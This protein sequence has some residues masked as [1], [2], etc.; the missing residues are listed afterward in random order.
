MYWF[1]SDNY[2]KRISWAVSAHQP[3]PPYFIYFCFLRSLEENER[4]L[5]NSFLCFSEAFGEC[6]IDMAG[7]QLDLQTGSR[8]LCAF[9]T[10]PIGWVKEG[11]NLQ[12]R[13]EVE[14]QLFQWYLQDITLIALAVRIWGY[15]VLARALKNR[16][17]TSLNKFTPLTWGL[18]KPSVAQRVSQYI[19]EPEISLP[20]TQEPA[21]G[22]YPEPHESNPSHPISQRSILIVS[23]PPTFKVPFLKSLVFFVVLPNECRK[24]MFTILF[25]LTST[26]LHIIITY[27]IDLVDRRTAV[28]DNPGTKILTDN[29]VLTNFSDFKTWFR[30]ELFGRLTV[31]FRN[32]CRATISTVLCVWSSSNDL[33]TIYWTLHV[34]K[35]V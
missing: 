19:M 8:H 1:S 15:L 17:F 16:V 20:C 33:V 26:S 14:C 4:K 5:L 10:K 24:G 22:P 31:V 7:C 27:F 13:S 30:F 35:I 3:S 9:F 23:T 28:C 29:G 2:E 6:V 32:A 12:R 34:A 25:P 21:T 18:E 11:H